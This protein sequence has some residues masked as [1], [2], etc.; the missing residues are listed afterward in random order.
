[1]LKIKW[2]NKGDSFANTTYYDMDLAVEKD[3]KEY[4]VSGTLSVM[5]TENMAIPEY[6]FNI[7]DSEIDFSKEELQELCYFAQENYK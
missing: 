4:E 1:M 2:A 5:Q 7:V 6:D 3:G